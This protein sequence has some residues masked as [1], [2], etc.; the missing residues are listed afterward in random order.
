MI[1]ICRMRVDAHTKAYVARKTTE[2]HSKLE[3]IRCLKRLIAREVYYLLRQPTPDL[4]P[5]RFLPHQPTRRHAGTVNPA[6]QP[7]PAHPRL[8]AP[9]T[10]TPSTTEEPAA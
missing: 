8:T 2:G 3:I 7:D 10:G 5:G 6:A 4:T 9:S 1:A